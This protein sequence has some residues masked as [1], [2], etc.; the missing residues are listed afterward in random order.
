MERTQ[1]IKEVS[2]DLNDQ[3]TNY[4]YIHWTKDLL[5]A[6]LQEALINLAYNLKEIFYK[7][8]IVTVN[9]NQVWQT[10]CEGCSEII[11]VYGEVDQQGNL[12]K[13]FYEKQD[14]NV[15]VGANFGYENCVDPNQPSNLYAYSLNK[16]DYKSFRLY[17]N[18]KPTETDRRILIQCYQEPDNTLTDIPYRL[19]AAIKQ[20]MLYRALIIDSENNSTIAEIAKT[21]LQTYTLLTT[22]LLNQQNR[23]E[24]RRNEQRNL[25]PQQDD[26]TREVSTRT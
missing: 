15:Y 4:E 18:L 26:N 20:W 9:P 21:H 3:V 24:V 11:K 5:A 19:V 8:I 13:V 7:K 2:K 22:E 1:I 23:L 14:D 6:Y 10:P 17:G 25:R 12:I 16:V